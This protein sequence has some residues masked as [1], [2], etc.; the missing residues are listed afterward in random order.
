MTTQEIEKFLESRPAI[1]KSAFCRE[2]GVSPQYLNAILREDK[3][4]T[5]G[6]SEKIGPV[7]RNYGWSKNK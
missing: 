7:M 1:N 3:P 4:M 6:V 5:E 2:V